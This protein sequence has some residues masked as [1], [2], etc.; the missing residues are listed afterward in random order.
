MAS[1][2]T[3]NFGS[4]ILI[5]GRPIHYQRIQE[6]RRS[7]NVSYLTHWRRL[8]H[9]CVIELIHHWFRQWLVAWPASSHYLNN[10]GSLLMGPR[11]TNF[12]KKNHQENAFENVV[13]K[14][15]TML[16]GLDMSTHPSLMIFICTRELGFHWCKQK[17]LPIPPSHY[18]NHSKV[19]QTS[20]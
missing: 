6:D 18:L 3:F 20:P 7:F 8:T 1:R 12:N 17:M 10:A 16:S 2:N 11:R 19:F 14:M 5:K 13:W 9:I 15:A 4:A